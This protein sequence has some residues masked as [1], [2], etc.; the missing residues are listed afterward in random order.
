MNTRSKLLC[1]CLTLLAG[2][3]VF[4]EPDRATNNVDDESGFLTV[5]A[6]RVFRRPADGKAGGINNE[7]VSI[8][9]RVSYEGLDLAM[10]AD[11]LELR[12]RIVE[13]AQ[14]GCEQLAAL[15]P[16]A[17]LDT[18]ACVREAIDDAMVRAQKVVA[19]AMEAY[20]AK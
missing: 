2:N 1:G 14:T 15:S 4:A 3:A 5:H 18:A 6:P 20:K 17:D 7:L 11:V 9:H 8:A 16:L 12:K 19:A 10:H 13:S